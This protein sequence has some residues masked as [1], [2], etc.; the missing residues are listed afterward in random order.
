MIS[1]FLTPYHAL[2]ANLGWC[3]K[4][5][6]TSFVAAAISALLALAVTFATSEFWIVTSCWIAAAAL[7][8]LWISHLA[9]FSLRTAAGIGNNTAKLSVVTVGTDLSR[10]GVRPSR[11]QFLSDAVKAF[12]FAALA[13]ALPSRFAFAQNPCKIVSCSDP[14]CTC[15]SPTRCVSCPARNEY[16]CAATDAVICCTVQA[17]WACPSRNDCFGNGTNLGERCRPWR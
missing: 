17:F 11:R 2:I 7:T 6:R 14:K 5:M 12:A 16:G 9:A 3:P 4:C 13:T 15:V 10:T 1:L 8:G